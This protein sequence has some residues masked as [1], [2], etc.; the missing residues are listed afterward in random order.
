MSQKFFIAQED[1]NR[2]VQLH[3][4]A[5]GFGWASGRTEPANFNKHLF[6]DLED[7]SMTVSDSQATIIKD[8]LFFC[9]GDDDE[10]HKHDATPMSLDQFG[11]RFLTIIEPIDYTVSEDYLFMITTYK[12]QH[13]IY[14]YVVGHEGKVYHF[15]TSEEIGSYFK[16]VLGYVVTKGKIT[17]PDIPKRKEGTM[18]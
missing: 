13:A 14:P 11:D 17:I 2:A 1:N 12:P 8:E 16:N 4:F 6:F 9:Y 18:G 3:L 7:R 10:L 5:N 15:K